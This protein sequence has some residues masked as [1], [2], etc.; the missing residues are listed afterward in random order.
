M[1]TWAWRATHSAALATSSRVFI[2]LSSEFGQKLC[3]LESR[4]NHQLLVALP[5]PDARRIGTPSASCPNFVPSGECPCGS[6]QL[7]RC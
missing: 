4:K 7:L 5:A 2:P 3:R 6:G 1:S